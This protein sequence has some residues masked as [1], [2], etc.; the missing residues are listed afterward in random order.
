MVMPGGK[1]EIRQ[2]TFPLP[3]AGQA[4][5]QFTLERAF[6]NAEGAVKATNS[7]LETPF[8]EAERVEWTGS[9]LGVQVT[10]MK[11]QAPA[12]KVGRNNPCPCGSG[13][14]YNKCHGR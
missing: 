10:P 7:I 13:L 6:K 9:K 1:T 3:E 5:A 4:A 8:T 14:K 11:P 12:G 2:Y